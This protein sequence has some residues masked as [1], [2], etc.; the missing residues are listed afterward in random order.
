VDEGGV[1][2]AFTYRPINKFLAAEI[3][4]NVVAYQPAQAFDLPPTFGLEWVMENLFDYHGPVLLRARIRTPN[5]ISSQLFEWIRDAAQELLNA[6]ENKAE[7]LLEQHIDEICASVAA[8]LGRRLLYL[9][10]PST[11][12]MGNMITAIRK[13]AG[14][15]LLHAARAIGEV[16]LYEQLSHHHTLTVGSPPPFENVLGAAVGSGKL[17][18]VPPNLDEF[19]ELRPLHDLCLY[20]QEAIFVA[21]R[22]HQNMAGELLCTCM[23][24]CG[25]FQHIIPGREYEC[26]MQC[27]QLVT[28]ICFVL[29]YA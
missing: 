10:I 26:V 4:H 27:I 6:R 2:K 13:Q 8:N 15:L 9:L 28:L 19:F 11:Y 18:P 25:T 12:S 22:A 5:G 16:R 3:L 21:I 1:M 14:S 24:D 20:L 17:D 7:V 23:R 29:H